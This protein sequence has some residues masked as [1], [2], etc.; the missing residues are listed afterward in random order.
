MFNCAIKGSE[1][2]DLPKRAR[3]PFLPGAG[4][5]TEEGLLTQSS[6]YLYTFPRVRENENV[7]DLPKATLSVVESGINPTVRRPPQGTEPH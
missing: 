2:D 4:E 3:L 5:Q 6:L 1:V 7:S